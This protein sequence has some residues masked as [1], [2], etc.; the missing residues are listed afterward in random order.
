MEKPKP[1]QPNAFPQSATTSLPQE[2]PQEPP[3]AYSPSASSYLQPPSIIHSP[4]FSP[5]PPHT[6][7]SSS[8]H[9]N[10]SF[11][12]HPPTPPHTPTIPLTPAKKKSNS[13]RCTCCAWSG[14]ICSECLP[15]PC[16]YIPLILCFP[17]IWM[18][19]TQD[20]QEWF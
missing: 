11:S 17:C 2:P 8:P 12:F 6:N 4:Y 1:R 5:L 20:D 3:P 13:F 10:P 15:G 14:I 9:T 19:I 16:G 7:S 18:C